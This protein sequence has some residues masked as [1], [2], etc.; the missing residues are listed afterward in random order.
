[1]FGFSGSG[2]AGKVNYIS[3][4]VKFEVS[5]CLSIAGSIKN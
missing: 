4:K 3:G 5:I 1:M 2:S